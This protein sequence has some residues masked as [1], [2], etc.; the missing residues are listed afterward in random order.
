[1]RSKYAEIGVTAT[2]AALS[3][4]ATVGNA[5]VPV[6]AVLGIAIF[7]SVGYVWVNVL[8]E[9]RVAGLERVAVATGLALSVPVLGGLVL[10]GAGIPLHPA[11]W[12]SLLAWRDSVGDAI[13]MA[14]A[15]VAHPTV[16]G[17]R[18]TTWLPPR[19][20][21]VIFGAAVAVAAGAVALASV[22]AA[23]QRYPGFTQLWLSGHGKT[24]TASLGVSNQ[25]GST[26]QY[27]LIILRKG[28]ASETWNLT[29]S[30]GQVWQEAIPISGQYA[31]AADL[32]LMPDLIH[33]YR[34][35]STGS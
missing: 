21:L 34:H 35:V 15:R 12:A 31:T 29:L 25:Q 33:P 17:K 18:S 3:F 9:H 27:R 19:L 7:A 11:A 20:H 28:R 16:A 13:L 10:Q 26:K 23:T 22:G 5:P 6:T 2:V 4:G 14:R 8:F 1:M 30:N 32:Y 24:D